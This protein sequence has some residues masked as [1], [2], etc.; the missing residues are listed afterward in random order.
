M[1]IDRLTCKNIS[2]GNIEETIQREK[3]VT[4]LLD[5]LGKTV[6]KFSDNVKNCN[7]AYKQ[8]LGNAPLNAQEI[9]QV[10]QLDISKRFQAIFGVAP[11]KANNK[12]MPELCQALE[13]LKYELMGIK[14][15]SLMEKPFKEFLA[16]K[17]RVGQTGINFYCVNDLQGLQSKSIPTTTFTSA[18]ALELCL[19][20]LKQV[21]KSSE[22]EDPKFLLCFDESNRKDIE[23]YANHP[24]QVTQK[25]AQDLLLCLDYDKSKDL[26]S[27]VCNSKTLS[28]LN[29][30]FIGNEKFKQNLVPCLVTCAYYH[31]LASEQLIKHMSEE[32]LPKAY[33][34]HIASIIATKKYWSMQSQAA[35]YD[36]IYPLANRIISKWK[37][38]QETAL[39]LKSMLSL[40]KFSD[41]LIDNDAI[42]NK[43]NL[44]VHKGAPI[45]WEE[46]KKKVPK[47]KRLAKFIE[48]TIPI[49][50]ECIEKEIVPCFKDKLKV[51]HS[52][53]LERTRFEFFDQPPICYTERVL[54]WFKLN[55]KEGIPFDEYKE[56]TNPGYL[57]KTAIRHRFSTRVDHFAFDLNFCYVDGDCRHLLVVHEYPD[58]SVDFGVTTFHF[59]D[60]EHTVCDHRFHTIL[61]LEDLIKRGFKGVKP[62]SSTAPLENPHS[63]T[64]N[65]DICW[66]DRK[67][68]VIE[69]QSNG[70]HIRILKRI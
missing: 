31:Y 57:E 65:S 21:N 30:K 29:I 7:D 20:Y 2:S 66:E 38:P 34:D 42:E 43:P 63:W 14:E 56:I 62:E 67:C 6:L 54:R 41:K 10:M 17:Q 47:K 46:D 23:T 13:F 59:I 53:K 40:K 3:R 68:V 25:F 11:E 70:I 8:L 44:A 60:K 24:D 18:S 35:L 64:E 5:V 28:H 50:A 26:F 19:Q 9:T 22:K 51:S 12:F 4:D 33:L 37:S 1:N 16:L 69:D 52:E 27:T 55:L 15:I 32:S 36:T 39:R 48:K 45:L 58:G 61:N 49:E